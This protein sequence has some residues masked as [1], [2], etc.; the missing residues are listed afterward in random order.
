MKFDNFIQADNCQITGKLTK[1]LEGNEQYSIVY[2]H[3]KYED[4]NYLGY[5]CESDQN[6]GIMFNKLAPYKYMYFNDGYR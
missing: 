1:N 4:I 2:V 6:R 5:A 3:F